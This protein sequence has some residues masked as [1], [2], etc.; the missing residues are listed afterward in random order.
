[1]RHDATSF[2][3]AQART[4]G[5]RF[6]HQ[7][8]STFPDLTVAENLMIGA[9]GASKF[10]RIRWP[11][12]HRRAG[13]LLERFEID[14]RPEDAMDRL[15]PAAQMMVA[16][17][18]ALQDEDGEQ[19]A[20]RILVLDEPTA[21]LPA[22]EAKLLLAA[23]TRYARAGQTIL[24]V[25]H[26]LDEVVQVADRATVVRDGKLVATVQRGEFDHASL[27]RLIMGRTVAAFAAPSHGVPSGR[28]L[29]EGRDLAGGPV[30]GASFSLH[31]GEIVGVA[32][33]LG[34]GRT[35]LLR[36][37]FGLLPPAGGELTIDREAVALGAP[38]A[39]MRRGIA[40]VPEDRP[41]EA[42]FADLDVTENLGMACTA[43]YFRGGRM[44]HR[45]ERRD[46][47][48]LMRSYL[49]KAAS[50]SARFASL[51]GGNQQKAILARW[52]RRDPRILL[53]D[54]PTQGVDVGARLEIWQLVR[55]AVERGATALV[56]SS[57]FE[58]LPAVCDR[59]L[60]MRAGRIVA[61][62]SGPDLD[63]SH[64]D[65][66]AMAAA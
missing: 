33:L 30:A 20:A 22:A 28:P 50:P 48:A 25:T 9:F 6:V 39:A 61:E 58:E 46:A 54:E 40:Y 43:R 52:L 36:L 56:V 35:S 2:S 32:G 55:A 11:A 16:I 62:L 1:V 44:R 47:A 42:A 4:A 14:A 26:R 18:R 24:Y 15:G 34:S 12:V 59:V 3:P 53:L 10:G 17:A 7:Q 29:L 5:L 45:E 41:K 60:V 57:D 8:S 13:A 37:L 63:P 49:I 23:L 21:A 19:A 38:H 64:L 27:V 51:S 31:A 66:L 65:H